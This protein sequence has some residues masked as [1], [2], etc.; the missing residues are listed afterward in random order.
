[1]K[2]IMSII[3]IG[4]LLLSGLGAVA[5][6]SERNNL[7]EFEISDQINFSKEPV[8]L[9]NE[10]YLNVEF[11]EANSKILAP[12]KPEI[13]VYIKTIE[14]PMHANNIQVFC[15]PHDIKTIELPGELTPVSTYY[16]TEDSTLNSVE[17]DSLYLSSEFYPNSWFTFQT[18]V[19]LNN[20]LKIVTKVKI[21][22]NIM[23]Y[24]PV[25]KIVEYTDG[26][27]IDLKYSYDGTPGILADAYDMVVI[28]PSA[29]ESTLQGYIDHK[30]SNGVQTVF[31]SVE[32]IL[33]DPTYDSGRD[34]PEKIKLFIKDA[35][36]NWGITYVFLVGGLTSYYN[37]DD[38]DGINYG[39]TDWYVPVR[40]TRIKEGDEVGCISDLYYGDIYKSGGVFEDWD[41]SG[42]G[43]FA[44]IGYTGT[45]DDVMDLDPD[46][47]V[48]RIPVRSKIE[49]KMVLNKLTKYDSTSPGEKA[50]FST[51]VCIAGR[52][53]DL[54]GDT[55]DGEYV[56]DT[57]LGYM[58]DLVD[59][60][61][62]VYASN[63]DSGGLIPV[64]KDISKAIRQGAG[65]VDFEGHGNPIAWNTHWADSD[66]WIGG[67]LLYDFVRF[68]NGK[69]RPIVIVGGC[70]NALFN[71]S[72]KKTTDT[73]LPGY[74]YWTYG[75]PAPVCFSWGMVLVPW[76]GAIGSTGCT[77]YGMGYQGQPLSLSAEMESDFFYE[78]GQDGATTL[79]QAHSGSISKF[80]AENSIGDTE[81]HCI[82]VY[83][84]FGDPSMPLGGYE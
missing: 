80:I 23:R 12:G 57:A 71:V 1:M 21:V 5:F 9:N 47:I 84:L 32:D 19:G 37:A 16:R 13:S 36:E 6:P 38:K 35:V 31:K 2:K 15:T 55:P 11:E 65:Y 56:C 43:I 58:G 17:K 60:D 7:K 40:Y 74:Y 49:L 66:D 64:K 33:A 18:T 83:Q 29:F 42:D 76:G 52:T 59:N 70:H 53:F 22:C 41:S 46:V 78:I 34:P 67:I 79:G 24:S 62:K 25:N 81:A 69:E 8:V 27:D 48:S 10:N 20:D 61:V 30:I 73:S 77:G 26:F 51:M 28:A 82:T 14:L 4:V 63:R 39:A 3:I 72:I 68:F 54:V 45:P 75:S 50:W 44:S